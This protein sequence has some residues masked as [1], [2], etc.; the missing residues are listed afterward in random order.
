MF[1]VIAGIGLV[2]AGSLMVRP[3]IAAAPTWLEI[4]GGGL[5]RPIVVFWADEPQIRALDWTWAVSCLSCEPDGLL[6]PNSPRRVD[7][8]PAARSTPYVLAWKFG[9]PVS[10]R[11]V[12]TAEWRY[13][14]PS[15]GN[16]GLM[17]LTSHVGAGFE[18]WFG[19]WFRAKPEND[20]FLSELL[21]GNG[22]TRGG[23]I[24]CVP[25]GQEH[26]FVR[27]KWA[28]VR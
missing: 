6:D 18:S 14:G 12:V 9:P 8:P 1:K 16:P 19:M 24:S 4:S 2:L 3:A 15:E 26:A 10:A 27:I 20:V 25:I 28:L 17:Q 11:E 7:G 23:G 13:Q 22:C 21:L 5:K